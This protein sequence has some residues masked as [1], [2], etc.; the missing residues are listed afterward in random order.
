MRLYLA[1]GRWAEVDPD[2]HGLLIYRNWSIKPHGK[3]FYAKTNGF[4]SC[5]E[6]STQY[7]HHFIAGKP[8]N[9]LEIDHIDGDGL[10]NARAN[11]RIVTRRQNMNNI[12]GLTKTSRFPGVYWNSAVKKWQAYVCVGRVSKYLGVFST[13]EASYA[14]RN[15]YLESIL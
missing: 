6:R 5:G 10:N 12:H 1:C 11:L 8:L 9:G 3:T 13:Q 7:L 15:A 2:I 4:H 14:V